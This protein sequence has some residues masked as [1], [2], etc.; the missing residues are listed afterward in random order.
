VNLAVY[1]D[2]ILVVPFAYLIVQIHP[3]NDLHVKVLETVLVKAA[4]LMSRKTCDETAA[5][6][7]LCTVS[8]VW[9]IVLRNCG[10]RKRVAFQH[11]VDSKFVS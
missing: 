9:W 8:H 11:Y 4:A 7:T 5:I 1:M 2:T 3:I 6:S 10:K